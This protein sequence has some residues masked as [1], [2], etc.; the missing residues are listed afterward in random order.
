SFLAQAS[1]A[2][3]AAP[4]PSTPSV[5][6]ARAKRARRKARCATRPVP[7]A[8]ATPTA[9]TQRAPATPSRSARSDRIPPGS[10]VVVF[11]EQDSHPNLDVLERLCANPLVAIGD[12]DFDVSVGAPAVNGE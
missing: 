11:A 1:R 3:P 12:E 10:L 4:A 7:N 9:T 5:I 8:W 2:R 6:W